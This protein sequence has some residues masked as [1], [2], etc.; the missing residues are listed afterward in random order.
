MREGKRTRWIYLLP[1][2]GLNWPGAAGGGGAAEGSS[3]LVSPAGLSPASATSWSS[4][5]TQSG[6]VAAADTSSQ[7]S[8][9]FQGLKVTAGPVSR[10][11]GR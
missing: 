10:S 4:S 8:E 6:A 2:A 9:T 5:I 1:L 11:S 7:R 3:D